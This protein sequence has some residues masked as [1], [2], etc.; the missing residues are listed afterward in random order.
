MFK[1]VKAVYC[2]SIIHL[3]CRISVFFLMLITEKVF[4]LKKYT[5][6][7]YNFAAHH[8]LCP[9]SITNC[10]SILFSTF[11]YSMEQRSAH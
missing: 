8:F 3:C 10:F 7:L 2:I 6:S 11:F 1:L 5:I 4:A 9:F